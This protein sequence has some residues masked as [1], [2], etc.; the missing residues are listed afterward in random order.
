M[1]LLRGGERE[2]LA[3]TVCWHMCVNSGNTVSLQ[4]TLTLTSVS[5]LFCIFSCVEDAYYQ[6]HSEWVMTKEEWKHSALW[7]QESPTHLFILAKS[8]NMWWVWWHNLSFDV[9]RSSRQTK[10]CRLLLSQQY[11]FWLQMCL[12]RSTAL[13]CALSAGWLKLVVILVYESYLYSDSRGHFSSLELCKKMSTKSQRK[14]FD[15][16]SPSLSGRWMEKANK[17]SS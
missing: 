8:Y 17:L 10:G 16:Y 9:H 13:Q 15:D 7:L 12:T 6:P 3:S 2:C 11:N 1:P 14:L 5:Q 4:D